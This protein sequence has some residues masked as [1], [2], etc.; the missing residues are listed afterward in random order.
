MVVR[1]QKMK[2]N[3]GIKTYFHSRVWPLALIGVDRVVHGLLSPE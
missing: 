3:S 2:N 1:L